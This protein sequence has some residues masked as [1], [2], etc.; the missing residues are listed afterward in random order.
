MRL[1]TASLRLTFN[2]MSKI[3]VKLLLLAHLAVGC[4][5]TSA[6]RR[7]MFDELVLRR[8]LDNGAMPDKRM[9]DNFM[10]PLLNQPTVQGFAD[11][12]RKRATLRRG[13]LLPMRCAGYRDCECQA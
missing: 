12:H 2:Q 3:G 11:V 13:S 9:T 4:I 5:A 10:G 1:S 7:L 8:S 6:R